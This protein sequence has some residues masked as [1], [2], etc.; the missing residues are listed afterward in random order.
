MLALYSVQQNILAVVPKE[1]TAKPDLIHIPA[2]SG[3]TLIPDAS[4]VDG[5]FMEVQWNGKTCLVFPTDL[6]ER[7]CRT[8]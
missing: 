4:P 6:E 2:G 1:E 3:L 8:N 5:R 7:A